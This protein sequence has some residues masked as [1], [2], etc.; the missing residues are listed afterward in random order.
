M[1]RNENFKAKYVRQLEVTSSNIDGHTQKI[2]D[3]QGKQVMNKEE[4]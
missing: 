3:S 2:R 1:D 4:V